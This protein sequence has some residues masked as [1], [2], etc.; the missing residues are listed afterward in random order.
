MEYNIVPVPR[1]LYWYTRNVT[2]TRTHAAV[3]LLYICFFKF[4]FCAFNNLIMSI[5]ALKKMILFG[6]N[7]SRKLK[8]PYLPVQLCSSKL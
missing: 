8:K 2:G 5:L 7:N 1:A 3:H 6:N 4:Y